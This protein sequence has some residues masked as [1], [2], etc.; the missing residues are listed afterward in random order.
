MAYLQVF[1]L[2]KCGQMHILP[3]IDAMLTPSINS[4]QGFGKNNPKHLYG[5][6]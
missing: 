5:A 1:Q 4:H 2:K 3:A 6:K